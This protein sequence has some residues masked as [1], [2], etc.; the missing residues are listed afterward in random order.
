[1][2][3]TI[4]LLSA[5][6]L[7]LA[8]FAAVGAALNLFPNGISTGTTAAGTSD[9]MKTGVKRFNL[10]ACGNASAAFTGTMKVY[11]GEATGK[12]TLTKSI[13]LTSLADCSEYRS[14]DPSGL[15]KVVIDRTSGTLD[16]VYLGP[17]Q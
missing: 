5:L 9:E 3:K 10:Q 8:P 17:T 13:T 7:L 14:Y 12:L 11:Q 16:A 2:K 4:A 15:A 6:V 1:V